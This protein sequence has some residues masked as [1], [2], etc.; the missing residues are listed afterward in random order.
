M[1]FKSQTA[2][3]DRFNRDK[4][5][6][7]AYKVG[8]DLGYNYL[9]TNVIEL[10]YKLLKYFLIELIIL[11]ISYNKNQNTEDDNTVVFRCKSSEITSDHLRKENKNK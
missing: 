10:F 2:I 8:L 6:R 3:N 4:F 7:E 9:A 5:F 1:L 11:Y